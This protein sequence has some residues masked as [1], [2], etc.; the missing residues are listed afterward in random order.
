[1]AS[2]KLGPAGLLAALYD[3]GAYTPLFETDD[4]AVI[5]AYG[6]VGG[7]GVYAVCQKGGAVSAADIGVSRRTLRLAAET[8][9]PVVTFYNSTGVKIDDGAKSLASVERLLGA[10]AKLSGVVPQLAVV[11]GVCGASSALLA[12]NADVVVM[13]RDA[14]LFLSPPFLSEEKKEGAGGVEAAVRSGVVSVVAESDA[15]AVAKAARLL[16]LLPQNNLAEAAGFEYEAPAAAWPGAKYTG[17]AAIEALCD[18][19]SAL[20]LFAGFGNGIITALCTVEGSVAGIAAAN[21]PDTQMGYLCAARAARFMRLCDAY[22]IPVITVLNSGG[23]VM[24]SASDEV[25]MLRQAARLA[26]TYGDATTAKLLVL[27]GNTYGAQYAA[28]GGADLCIALEGSVTAP[29]EPGAAVTVLYK[30]EIEAAEGSIEAETEARAKAYVDEVAGAKALYKAGLANFVAQG[31]QAR[32]VVA[33]ALDILASKR[34]SRMP[35][36]HGNMAL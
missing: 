25:G 22:S 20:E 3:G 8:G 4:D 7:Q 11:T 15:D 34:A 18:A 24:D 29:V 36:K 33:K 17:M 9:N 28:M 31:A 16:M 27:A 10:G 23:F 26:A 19:G 5:S 13:T 21:G 12:A 14:E 6:T 2:D 35:K 1:M 32:G 30:S